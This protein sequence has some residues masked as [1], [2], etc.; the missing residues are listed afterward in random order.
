MAVDTEI[1]SKINKHV[2]S[3]ISINKKLLTEN[4]NLKND[5]ISLKATLSQKEEQLTKFKKENEVLSVAKSLS[6]DG[7]SNKEA[8]LKIN[9]LVREIDKCISLLN[10]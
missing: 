7:E 2:D 9:E 10:N 3:L 5:I 4:G 1:V 8:K 6:G